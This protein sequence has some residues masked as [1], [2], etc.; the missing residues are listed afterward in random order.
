M[1]RSEKETVVQDVTEIFQKAKSVF[2]TD[3]EGPTVEKMSVPG[4][5]S[6]SAVEYRW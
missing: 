4:R 2:V 3:Y 5:N 6:A 1:Q